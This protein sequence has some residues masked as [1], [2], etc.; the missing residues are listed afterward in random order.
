MS[1]WNLS[2]QTYYNLFWKKKFQKTFC[3]RKNILLKNNFWSYSMFRW[4]VEEAPTKGVVEQ[5]LYGMATVY[6]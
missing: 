5:G 3:K 4:S 1:S 6:M 2:I